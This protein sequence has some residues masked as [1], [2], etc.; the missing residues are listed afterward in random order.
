MNSEPFEDCDAG[1]TLS[2]AVL[3]LNT[4]QHN[5]N[6]KKQNVPMNMEVCTRKTYW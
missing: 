4:D 5:H 2:Y 1:F 6:A 3:M